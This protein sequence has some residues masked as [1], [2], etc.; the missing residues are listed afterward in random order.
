MAQH[1]TAVTQLL[2]HWRYTSLVLSYWHSVA[3]FIEIRPRCPLNG[4]AVLYSFVLTGIVR[5]YA[6]LRSSKSIPL[7]STVFSQYIIVTFLWRSQERN[8]HSWPTRVKYG[9]SFI[10]EKSDR[11]YTIITFWALCI[12][13]QYMTTIYWEFVVLC[14]SRW[15]YNMKHVYCKMLI[16]CFCK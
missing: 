5:Q 1:K 4:L 3:L 10:F 8:P 12:I 11:S 7:C 2:T 9:V 16:T 15:I 6:N 14:I 13:M